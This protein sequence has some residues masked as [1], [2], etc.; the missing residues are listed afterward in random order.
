MVR[1]NNNVMMKFGIRQAAKVNVTVTNSKGDIA[2]DIYE[3]FVNNSPFVGDMGLQ[4][5][6]NPYKTSG[7]SAVDD[8][9]QINLTKWY[10]SSDDT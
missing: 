10:D 5:A 2:Y 8:L 7:F 9:L 1:L 4:V 3:F 6:G